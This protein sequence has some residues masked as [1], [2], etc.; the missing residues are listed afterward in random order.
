MEVLTFQIIS[1]TIAILIS[2]FKKTRFFLPFYTL[3]VLLVSFYLTTLKSFNIF[4]LA[5]FFI[6]LVILLAFFKE[7][8]NKQTFYLSILFF[9]IGANLAIHS[10]DLIRILIGIEI[11]TFSFY[12]L[13]SINKNSI[14]RESLIKYFLPNIYGTSLILFSFSLFYQQNLLLTYLMF[15]FLLA[16]FGLKITLFPFGLWAPD[17]YQGTN[18]YVTSLIS[19]VPK[20]VYLA[21]MLTIFSTLQLNFGTIIKIFSIISLILPSVIAL[22]QKDLKRL[23]AY[24]SLSQ[25]GFAIITFYNINEISIKA[26]QIFLLYESISLAPLFY[27]NKFFSSK[28]LKVI[29]VIIAFSAIGIPPL[30]GFWGKYLIFLYAIKNNLWDFLIF[31]LISIIISLYYIMNIFREKIEF[32]IEKASKSFFLSNILIVL[33]LLL[34]PIF[35]LNFY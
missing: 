32:K 14:E 31:A 3:A 27:F 33:F 1:L 13:F 23:F 11:V 15:S 8:E 29:F 16:G 2:S 17:V 26:L 24:F 10:Y 25:I 6:L 18:S 28:F 4:D 21:S 12:P 30:G 19:T 7:C 34:S 20:I 22:A 9:I 5:I 35:I